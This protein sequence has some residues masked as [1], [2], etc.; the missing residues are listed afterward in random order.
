MFS[1]QR[2]S[3]EPLFIRVEGPCF[4]LENLNK[5]IQ[6]LPGTET[7]FVRVINTF[8]TMG[9]YLDLKATWP[10][11]FSSFVLMSSAFLIRT[12]KV[13]YVYILFVSAGLGGI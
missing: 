5:Q 4:A 13:V 7:H 12:Y 6:C 3:E 11:S 10:N 2:S 8:Y 1:L 9:Y